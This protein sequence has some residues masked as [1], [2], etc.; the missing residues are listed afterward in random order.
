MTAR[1]I[2]YPPIAEELELLARK[3]PSDSG[4]P[5]TAESL[6]FGSKHT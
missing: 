2:R 1:P 4:E 3:M 6:N 5:L